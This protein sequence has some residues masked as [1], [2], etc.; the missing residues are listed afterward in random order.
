VDSFLLRFKHM[1]RTTLANVFIAGG[2]VV[3]VSVLDGPI[4][5][6]SGHHARISPEARLVAIRRAQVWTATK[7]PAMDLKAGPQGPGAF[8]PNETVTCD[9]VEKKMSGRSPK[10]TCKLAKDDEVKVKYGKENGEVYGEVAA[11]R[12][13]W[14]LGFG[15]DRM[16]PVRVVCRG[17]PADPAGNSKP[18]PGEATFD[19]AAI[20]REAEGQILESKP[21]SGWAWPE[22]DLVQETAG[23]APLAHRDALKLLAVFI[24]HTDSKPEQQRLMC[25]PGEKV[26]EGGE[27]CLHTFMMISDLG[28]TFGHANVYNRASVGSVNFE[29]WSRAKVWSDA[30]ACIGDISRSQTG[31]L[32]HPRI[33]EAGRKFLGDLLVQLS[34]AQLRDLF[35]VARFPERTGAGR[36]ATV[37]EWV[38]A[39]KKKRDEILIN[40]CPSDLT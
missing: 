39:F 21:G 4:S 8:A 1:N 35:A 23:G 17:C 15:A 29:Q 31:T 34:D 12:L 13:L 5:G 16:Y 18:K 10:F 2:L 9:Y 14:A 40:P 37:D 3:S 7:V 36:P 19:P 20:E 11:T 24:Q 25:A 32:D 30:K 33:S 6:Q 38:G 28:L 27:P 26:G 22:L